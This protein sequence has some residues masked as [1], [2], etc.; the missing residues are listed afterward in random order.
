MPSDILRMRKQYTV[1]LFIKN[2]I[3][4]EITV[5]YLKIR[6]HQ[7]SFDCRRYQFTGSDNALPENSISN[8][9][10]NN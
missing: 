6:H 1:F 10:L 7:L 2:G 4:M 3:R 5:M 9:Q 8:Y